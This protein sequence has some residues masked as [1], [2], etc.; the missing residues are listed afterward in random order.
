MQMGAA[1]RM[2]YLI[3]SVHYVQSVDKLG[4]MFINF[5]PSPKPIYYMSYMCKRVENYRGMRRIRSADAWRLAA[6]LDKGHRL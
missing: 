3:F 4:L 2:L 6:N 1:C 5:F